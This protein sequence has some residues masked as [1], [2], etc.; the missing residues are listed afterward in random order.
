LFAGSVIR[1]SWNSHGVA[2][3][4]ASAK[5]SSRLLLI[6]CQLII[7]FLPIDLCLQAG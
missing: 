5:K 2:L 3:R 6:A 7:P 1:L 4:A